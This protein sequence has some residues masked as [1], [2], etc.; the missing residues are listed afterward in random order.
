M[1]GRTNVRNREEC[2]FVYVHRSA[3]GVRDVIHREPLDAGRCAKADG[4][5]T[6][7]LPGA[8]F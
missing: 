2:E 3:V 4:V 8:D 6:A 5:V 1:A 7:D